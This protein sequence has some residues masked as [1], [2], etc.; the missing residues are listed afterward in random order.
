[1]MPKHY[2]FRAPRPERRDGL[3]ARRKEDLALL[4]AAVNLK[5]MRDQN[6]P[7]E[8]I[9]QQIDYL[10]DLVDQVMNKH[11][12]QPDVPGATDKDAD[13]EHPQVA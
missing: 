1:M 10:H 5:I 4:L 9:H 6:A 11:R 7:I 12:P 3:H 8:Q 13:H 2:D